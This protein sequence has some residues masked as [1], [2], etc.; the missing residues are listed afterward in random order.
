MATYAIG[1][2]HGCYAT[3]LG[4]MAQIP[5]DPERDRLWFVGD[6]VNRG[7]ASLSTLRWVRDF[8]SRAT[9]VLGN[10]DLHLLCRAQGFREDK[11]RDTLS[12]I[13]EAPDKRELLRWLRHRPLLVREGNSVLVHAGI[14]PHWTLETAQDRA[15]EAEDALRGPDFE[16]VLAGYANLASPASPALES[17]LETLR[18][19][20]LLRT[21]DE[22]GKRSPYS[23][24]PEQAP[25]GLRP[26]YEVPGRPIRRAQIIFGHWAA[27]GYR[28]LPEANVIALDSGCVWGGALTAIRLED[29]SVFQHPNVEKP[30][31]E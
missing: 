5:F 24:P 16:E 14:P 13:L 26:W 1:D 11:P 15:R 6:L 29:G 9:T 25:P 30:A 20:T 10:H 27:L 22:R 23:G 3:T 12:E 4:L 19:L 18:D 7:P 31:S 2:L 8:G 21:C 17:I 28:N